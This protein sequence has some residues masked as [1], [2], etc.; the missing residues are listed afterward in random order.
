MRRRNY[1][2]C[3]RRLWRAT[4]DARLLSG[5]PLLGVVMYVASWSVRLAVTGTSLAVLATFGALGGPAAHAAV[6]TYYV[7][8]T[9]CSDSG[10]G[11]MNQPFCT[12]SKAASIVTTGQ[13]VEVSSGTYREKVT[14]ASSGAPGSPVVFRAAP[15]AVVTVT[16]GTDGFVIS[17][18]HDVTISGFAVTATTSYGISVSSSSN[19]VLS[20]NSAT[21]AGQPI[22]GQIAAG[23]KV[24][25]TTNSLITR[26]NTS[27]NSDSGIYLA[28]GT[29]TTTV[30]YNESS[31]NANQYRRNA[32]G[33]NVISANNTIIGNVLHD[34]EDSGLQFYTGG[35]NNLATL[36]VSYNNGDHGIDDFN[37]TGGRL[38]GNT[39]YHNCTSGINVEGT[40][41]TY[42][43]K[44]NISVD[45]AVFRVNP[46]P[47]QGYTN[48]C[49]RRNGNIGIWDSAPSTTS[50][51]SNLVYLST[52][53]TMYVFG[54]AY[55]SIAA[56][57][58][59]T[60]QEQNGLQA[61]PRFADAAGS[62]LR[63]IEG[64][65]AIDSADS[66]ANGEQAN[67]ILGN[68][69]TDDPQVGN[70]G[71]GPVAFDD[72]GAY[73]VI[74]GGAPAPLPPV[75]A[76]TV[77]PATGPAPLLVTAGASNST[78]PQGQALTFSFSFGDGT[79]AGPQSSPRATHTF[80]DS[81]NYTVTVT[82][83][84]TAGLSDTASASVVTTQPSGGG[85]PA[86]VSQIATN[87]STSNHTSGAITVWRAEGVAAG[88][89]EV[90]T[91]QL[92]GTAPSG[93]VSG[94]D[95]AGNTLAVAKDIADSDGHRLV[96]LYGVVH[97]PL[98]PN[99]KITLTFPTAATYR[100]TGD[101]VSG[102]S[103][104]DRQAAASGSGG[105]YASGVTDTTTS[106]NEFVYGAV[107]LY[108]GTAPTWAS[109]WTAESTYAVGTSYLGRA[110]KI[111]NA[112][113]SFNAVGTGSGS[114]LAI[115]VTLQ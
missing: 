66:G 45:N 13:A 11:T 103:A 76:L 106:A 102:V 33:I 28:S 62:D 25:G 78:D 82:A 39:V 26:N 49:K 21:Y 100:L 16:G 67:D 35:D 8:G 53:G 59:A 2:G 105:P 97:A 104:P 32:N 20:G 23:I 58:A 85:N 10:S 17:N 43:V 96:V 48:D 41:G 77:A 31:L 9:D 80:T 99:S 64:S 109:G 14:I 112:T 114:W 19:I 27:H 68:P 89:L 90:L 36:N 101:E 113:G 4:R 6:T 3:I 74:A 30:S 71:V 115:C 87:Y 7:G 79:T 63:L 91:L 18:K 61:D 92:S 65:P 108:A 52:A 50:V 5:Q 75:A 60:G 38:I 56:M 22:S 84:D 73:E 110:Y 57:R 44:N 37:V 95:D 98:V 86:Y 55:S 15:A 34:N 1:V 51:D 107:A 69:R 24:S 42:L 88:H 70:T 72:R 12:I 83:T 40:S 111:T 54:S 81:G 46:T 93:A 29:T 94:S 47:E